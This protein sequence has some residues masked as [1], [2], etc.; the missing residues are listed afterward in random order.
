MEVHQLSSVRT[1]N[2]VHDF[3]CMNEAVKFQ[4]WAVQLAFVPK[5]R[6]ISQGSFCLER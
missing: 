4:M 6:G 1:E 5:R 2:T 3:P